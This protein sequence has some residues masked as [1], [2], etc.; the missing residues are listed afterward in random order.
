MNSTSLFQITVK[1]NSSDE[2][3]GLTSAANANLQH[4]HHQPKL[5]KEGTTEKTELDIKLLPESLIYT[6]LFIL[7]KDPFEVGE[8][9]TSIHVPRCNLSYLHLL[10]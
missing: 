10:R 4:E 6:K 8:N 2:G 7:A 3:G 9:I 1:N 5:D